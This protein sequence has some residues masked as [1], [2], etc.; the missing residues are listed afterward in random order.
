MF[1][2]CDSHTIVF[3]AFRLHSSVSEGL[4]AR[5]RV[6]SHKKKE[7]ETKK[8]KKKIVVGGGSGDWVVLLEEEGK[9]R[10]RFKERLE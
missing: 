2:L 8:K 3:A 6:F 9:Q 10:K 7:E 4:S 5:F 1:F